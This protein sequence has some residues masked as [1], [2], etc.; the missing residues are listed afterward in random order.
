MKQH[1][2]R[3]F[4]GLLLSGFSGLAFA[5]G[6]VSHSDRMEKVAAI[7]KEAYAQGLYPGLSIAAIASDGENIEYQIGH[8]EL[9][10]QR[11][12]TSQTT[13]RMYSVS[14][15]LTRILAAVLV[16]KDKLDLDAQVSRY[17]PDVPA[18]LHGIAVRQLLDHT[19]GIRH[20]RGTDEW[21]RLSRKSCSSPTEAIA[22]FASDPLLFPPGSKESYSSFG[23]VLL[24]AVLETAGGTP[25]DALMHH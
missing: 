9:D 17:L 6:A 7:A 4:A 2:L 25:F 14:K 13:F 21:L 19:S 10:K 11:P 20:Y 24:S 18:H 16:D 12:I 5:D 15:G 8:A 1:S 23:Y 3:F 22:D